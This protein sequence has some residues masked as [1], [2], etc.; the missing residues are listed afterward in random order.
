MNFKFEIEKPCSHT[1]ARAGKLH[2]PH[3]LIE[4]PV[5]M[6]VGTQGTVKAMTPANLDAVGTQIIL[7]NTYHLYLRPGTEVIAQAGGLHKFMHW[8][9][10]ILTDSGGYQVFSLTSMRK[11]TEDG[12]TFRSQIDGSEHCFTPEKVMEIEEILGADIIMPLDE[13]LPYP[14]DKD[15]A[16]KAWERTLRWIKRAKEAH[17]NDLQ[18]LFAIVQGGTYEDLR[19]LS[20][21]QLVELDFPGYAIG[22]LSVGEPK[23][24]MLE[25]LEKTIPHLPENRPRY[26]M[27]VGK[28]EDFITGVERGVDMFDCVLPTRIART[29]TLLTWSGKIVLKNAQ[30]RFDFSPPDPDCQCYTCSNFTK[31]YLRHLFISDEILGSML[32]TYHNIFFSL[33]IVRRIRQAILEDKFLEF[34]NKYLP[35]F[36][37]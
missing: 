17:K 2:T 21:K 32:A 19:A 22:G 5:F 1:R 13:C 37:Q 30:Y 23:D 34:K 28:P 25:M 3:G 4:T 20:A 9:K 33:E 36:S 18:A 6:P 15:Y 7:G 11:I 14:S 16:A 10:P 35:V 12:V 26:L 24:I 27:G 8:D 29:G 31:A